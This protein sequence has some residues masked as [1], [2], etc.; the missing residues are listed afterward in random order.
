[1]SLF[2][3]PIYEK[4]TAEDGKPTVPWLAFFGGIADGDAG[5]NWTPTYV[6]LSSS[7]TPTHSG[8]Y[9][10]LNKYITYF[11]AKITPATSVTATAGTTYIDNF[12]LNFTNDGFCVAVS[13]NLGATPGHIVSANNRVYIPTLSAVTVPVYIIGIGEAG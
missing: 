10:R 13:G 11:V 6:N 3:P 8:R 5:S 9:Y 7:G 1:M 12:P 4:V 2:Q